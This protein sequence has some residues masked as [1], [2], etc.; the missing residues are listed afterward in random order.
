M[1]RSILLVT[2]T[3]ANS[4]IAR[5]ITLALQSGGDYIKSKRALE[6]HREL[7]ATHTRD[8]SETSTSRTRSARLWYGLLHLWWRSTGSI[9]RHYRDLNLDI[10]SNVSFVSIVK[11]CTYGRLASYLTLFKVNKR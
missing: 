3:S 1:T 8:L 2:R 6:W 10:L 5:T 4:V 9:G 11:S 7:T